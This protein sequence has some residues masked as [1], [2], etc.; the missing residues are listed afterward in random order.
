MNTSP[1][2]FRY[3]C[4]S[5]NE[6]HEGLPD[7]TFANPDAY[8][9]MTEAERMEQALIDEDFCIID[10]NRYFLRCLAEAPIKGFKESFGW[11][12][13]CELE[14]RPFKKVWELYGFEEPIEPL[15]FSARLA[16]KLR[17]YDDTLDLAC[18]VSLLDD[19]MR[20]HLQVT[21][22]RHDFARHQE[23]GMEI[24]EAVRQARTVGALL[25]VG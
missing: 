17:H 16:N 19:G 22:K 4:S 14:W 15:T 12:V 24:E 8:D 7:V 10:G 9:A 6:L 20:P 18:E 25:V 1:S 13:W 2:R 11:G 21:D 3:K 5:C 23:E